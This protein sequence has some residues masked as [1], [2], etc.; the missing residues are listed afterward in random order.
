MP[1]I[2]D[3]QRLIVRTFGNNIFHITSIFGYVET[4]ISLFNIL[5]LAQQLYN[6]PI[7]NDESEIT[8]FLPNETIHVNTHG[9]KAW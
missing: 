6:V 7:T 5:Y 8:F 1:S 3:D 9:W 2:D 4:N